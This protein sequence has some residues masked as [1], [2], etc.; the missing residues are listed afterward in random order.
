MANAFQQHRQEFEDLRAMMEKD[1]TI[2]TIRNDWLG[3]THGATERP[4]NP[5]GTIDPQ[6]WDQYR[7]RF[8]QLRLQGGISRATKGPCELYFG[9]YGSGSR[10]PP[11][12]T[13]L[14]YTHFW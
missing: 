13:R 5:V 4:G 10:R 3:P 14:R 7:M 9:R 11:C 2:Q 12:D 8:R 1:S 6:R